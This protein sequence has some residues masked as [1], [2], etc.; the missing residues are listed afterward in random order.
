M[1]PDY[2]KLPMP[3]MCP[4]GLGGL[5]HMLNLCSSTHRDAAVA[6]PVLLLTLRLATRHDAALSVLPCASC[7]LPLTEVWCS[8]GRRP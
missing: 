1:Q 2:P 5:L 8:R 6:I 4:A 3:T 7:G